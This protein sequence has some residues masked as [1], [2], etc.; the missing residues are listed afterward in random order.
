MIG[1]LSYRSH[2]NAQTRHMQEE[3]VALVTGP[4]IMPKHTTLNKAYP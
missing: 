1:I 3:G 4:I 2:Y